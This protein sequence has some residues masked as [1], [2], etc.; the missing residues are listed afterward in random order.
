MHPSI[1]AAIFELFNCEQIH[2]NSSPDG[3][4]ES[5]LKIDRSVECFSPQWSI[6]AVLAGLG[7]V[8]I[9]FGWPLGVLLTLRH[10]HETI[11]IRDP[12]GGEEPVFVPRSELSSEEA[13]DGGS[14]VDYAEGGGGE[15]E[16][17]IEDIRK[18]TWTWTPRGKSGAEAMEVFPFWAISIGD[19]GVKTFRLSTRLDTDIITLYFGPFFGDY[20]DE[21]Y[22]WQCYEMLRR[23]F[24]T[25]VV[26]VIN[27]ISPG[28][29]VP[30]A[31]LVAVL[32][33]AIHAYNRPYIEDDPDFLQFVVLSNQFCI[34]FSLTLKVMD[35][36][37]PVFNTLMMVLQL[38]LVFTALF[39][40]WKSLG[41]GILD[42][43]G[44]SLSNAKQGTSLLRRWRSKKR[45]GKD[46]RNLAE[47]AVSKLILISGTEEQRLRVLSNPRLHKHFEVQEHAAIT[48][49][50][51][52]RRWRAKTLAHRP[53]EAGVADPSDVSFLVPAD[54]A[55]H[56]SF[57]QAANP[58]YDSAH[59]SS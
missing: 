38:I 52:C 11:K 41:P 12:E 54:M 40:V 5:W 22:W 49:Q 59:T 4:P 53:L 14:D 57:K 39:Y 58:S 35:M 56:A 16:E 20:E 34:N 43:A 7:A 45:M 26:I 55:S 9:V 37:P 30:F 21:Y 50:R 46:K 42:M 6:F 2:M 51:A 24:Q 36:M 18:R 1:S 31:L 44:R 27:I 17:D 3:G 8:F 25:S 48:I 10:C 33:L 47:R 23:L 15:K 32:A 19:G 28:L 29:D 13:S